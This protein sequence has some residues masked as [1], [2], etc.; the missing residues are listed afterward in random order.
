MCY[1]DLPSVN[2]INQCFKKLKKIQNTALLWKQ[3]IV[4]LLLFPKSNPAIQNEMKCKIHE[5]GLQLD[6][7]SL[8]QHVKIACC[9]PPG[10]L[11]IGIAWG[12][13]S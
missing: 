11:T 3:R 4:E 9:V 12:G 8:T 10:E 13:K 2:V 1:L 7:K 6:H 5:M